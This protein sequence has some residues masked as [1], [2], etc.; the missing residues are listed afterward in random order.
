MN[1]AD[2]WRRAKVREVCEAINSSIHP[3]QNSSVVARLR[4]DW[5]KAA[6]RPFRRTWIAE[7]LQALAPK[8]WLE[9]AYAVGDR[10]TLA[11]ILLAVM[12]RKAQTLGGEPLPA[13]ERHWQHL[14]AQPAVAGSCPAS[15]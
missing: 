1:Y 2:P 11:D 8:L 12:A 5:D 3:V 7:N 4:P 15:V 10:F 13:F 6:M 9:S 14:M